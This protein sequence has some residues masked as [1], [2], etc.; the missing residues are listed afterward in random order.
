MSQSSRHMGGNI[1]RASQR[2]LAAKAARQ[3]AKSEAQVK[4]Q[5][6][7]ATAKK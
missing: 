6:K 2:R 1:P 4:P 3:T 7:S 5:S